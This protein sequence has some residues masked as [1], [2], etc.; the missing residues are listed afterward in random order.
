MRFF[1]FILVVLGVALAVVS[2]FADVLGIGVDTTSDVEVTGEPT[3]SQFG[4]KQA[5][6]LA[7]GVV[8]IVAGAAM[9]VRRSGRST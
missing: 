7:V 9:I 2:G 5:L 3:S 6:G 8:L 1:A 4:W